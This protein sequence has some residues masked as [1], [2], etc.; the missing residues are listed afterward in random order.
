MK[1]KLYRIKTVYR[2]GVTTYDF[3]ESLPDM[4]PE[5]MFDLHLM[6]TNNSDEETESIS[7]LESDSDKVIAHFNFPI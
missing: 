7:M 3:L 6:S 2:D 4:S 5:A 1:A